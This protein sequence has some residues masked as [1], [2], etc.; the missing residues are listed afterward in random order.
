MRQAAAGMMVW[1]F[2]V[3]DHSAWVIAWWR[4]FS[5]QPPMEFW[6]HIPSGCQVCDWGIWSTCAMHIE[7]CEG[8][9][10][11]GC[12]GSSQRCPGFDSQWLP[13]FSAFSV[14]ASQYLYFQREARCS[15]NV[16]MDCDSHKL[17]CLFFVMYS[18]PVR[19]RLM[20]SFDIRYAHFIRNSHVHTDLR[21]KRY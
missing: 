3:R 7:D 13:A 8:W 2:R 18:I 4:E 5:G 19:A 10:L 11:P 14:F 9:W 16:P 6:W 1:A 21:Y 17:I 15:E 12:C 20:N